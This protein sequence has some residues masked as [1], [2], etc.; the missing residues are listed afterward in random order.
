MEVI[1]EIKF[2]SV[3]NKDTASYYFVIPRNLD[4]HL[5]DLNAEDTTSG[6]KLAV[7]RV[8]QIA[9]SVLSQ[10]STKKNTSDVI[11]FRID[12]K[13]SK[14]STIMTVK[15]LYKRRKQPFP[16]VI[17][18]REHEEQLLKVVDSKYYLSL[19]PTKTQ[20]LQFIYDTNAFV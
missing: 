5:I 1:N 18:L 9:P 12:A 10:Y 16:S 13:L 7:T 2:K 6:E 17:S 15:E 8:D 11:F 14:G 19:Y 3:S 20:K 4:S